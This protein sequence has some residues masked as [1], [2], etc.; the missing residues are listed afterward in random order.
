MVLVWTG[1]GILIF[2]IF[3]VM[4]ALS[5]VFTITE[6]ATRYGL[7]D[8]QGVNLT[9]AIAAALSAIVTFPIGRL[10]MRQPREKTVADPRTGQAYIE[11]TYDT[12]IWIDVTYWTYVFAVIAVIMAAV[13]FIF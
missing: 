13:A 2:F 10:V 4:A 7:T 12:F 3:I 5:L 11:R 6:I 8:S 9:I 1:R